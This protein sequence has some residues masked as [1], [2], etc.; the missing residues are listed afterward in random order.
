[1]FGTIGPGEIIFLVVILLLIF[2]TKRIPEIGKFF[3]LGLKEFKKASSDL[4]E[5]FEL[6][7]NQLNY[8]NKD[9]DKFSLKKE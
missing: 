2:G 1:M 8:D 4:K 6:K 7:D 3:G 9:K 5:P